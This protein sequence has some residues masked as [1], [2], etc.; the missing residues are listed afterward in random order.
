MFSFR[1]RYARL[2]SMTYVTGILWCAAVHSAVM[3]YIAAPSEA[4]P[5]TLRSGRASAAPSAP[6]QA[7][8]DAAAAHLDQLPGLVGC[9]GHLDVLGVGHAFRKDQRRCPGAPA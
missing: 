7:R 9:D 3:L 4:T 2:L 1:M 5:T 8:A 6:G